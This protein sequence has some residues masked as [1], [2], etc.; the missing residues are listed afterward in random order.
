VAGKRL[1]QYDIELCHYAVGNVR[2]LLD[3]RKSAE[4]LE[5]HAHPPALLDYLKDTGNDEAE[6][7]RLLLS[8]GEFN[9]LLA[10]FLELPRRLDPGWVASERLHGDFVLTIREVRTALTA[11]VA[12][13]WARDCTRFGGRLTQPGLRLAEGV[14]IVYQWTLRLR[15]L[16]R[17]MGGKQFLPPP[18]GL[19]PTPTRPVPAGSGTTA[20]TSSVDLQ[21]AQLARAI[22]AMRGA[23][24]GHPEK[25]SAPVKALRRLARIREQHA[26]VALGWLADRGEYEGFDPRRHARRRREGQGLP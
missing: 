3:E 2:Q 19:A 12:D 20:T 4:W 7:V 13:A 23:I 9:H 17:G 14:E 10:A 24:A 15:Q 16:L 22:D 5:Q 11:G 1:N 21:P 18:D 8:A 25:A 26:R 6:P